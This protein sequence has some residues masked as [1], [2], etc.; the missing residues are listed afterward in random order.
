MAT[1]TED[2]RRI[3]IPELPSKTVKDFIPYL[4]KHPQTPV[5]VLLQPFKAFESELRKVYAQQPGHEVVQ[6][7][8]VNL[9]PIFDGY[10]KD[11]KIRA[12]NLDAETDDEKAK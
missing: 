3:E 8:T 11:L 10:E 7:G 4:A 1:I 5:G 9:V 6:D 2:A 12:R